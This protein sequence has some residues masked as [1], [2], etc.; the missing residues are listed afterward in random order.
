MTRI[1]LEI[2]VVVLIV[3]LASGAWAGGRRRRTL[4]ERDYRQAERWRLEYADKAPEEDMLLR[5]A[6]IALLDGYETMTEQD[7]QETVPSGDEK[8]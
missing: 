7:T 8:G 1:V 4:M 6:D 2:L 5:S 3:Y